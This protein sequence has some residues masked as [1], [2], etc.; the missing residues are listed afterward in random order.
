VPGEQPQELAIDQGSRDIYVAIPLTHFA[1][2]ASELKLGQVDQLSPSGTPT[3]SSPFAAEQNRIFTGVAV[4]PVTHGVYALETSIETPIGPFG[5]SGRMD[6]F[7]SAGTPG[8]EFS[9]GGQINEGPRI[10]ADSTGRVFVP[11]SSAGAVLVYNSSGTL[12]E[13]ITCESCSGGAF[14]QPTSVALDSTDG[15][16]VV[17]VGNDRVVKLTDS[18]GPYAYASL[19]QS[20]KHAAAVGVDPSDNSIFVGDYPGGITYHIVAYDS[21]GM[22]F[23]DFGAGM[24]A[25]VE[26]GPAAAGQIAV[27]ATTHKLYASDPAGNVLHV[28]ELVTINPPTATT[29]IAASVG[30]VEATMK[31][32]VNAN[33]HATTDCH[34]EYADDTSFLANG[35][36]GSSQAPC[37]SRPDGSSPTAV[38]ARLFPLSPDTTYHYRVVA[39]N[40]AGSATGDAVAFSTLSQ[41]PATV[42]TKPASSVVRS[43]ATLNGS[44]N[45][46]SGTVTNCRFEYGPSQTYGETLACP[47]SIGITSSEVTKSVSLS[48]LTPATTYHYRFSVT[49]NAGPVNGEDL[50]VT[51]LAPPPPEEPAPEEA[52]GQEVPFEP[53]QPSV[54]APTPLVASPAKRLVCRKGFRKRRIR[55]KPHCVKKKTHRHKRR[56]RRRHRRSH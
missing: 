7:S 11:S 52:E 46:H 35:F 42:T 41:T 55:G 45:T 43:A 54:T 50:E 19:L 28:F 5:T 27:D 15:L 13:T 51:T 14:Q 22:R 25:S 6:Q 31:A 24:F 49:T 37:S 9:T 23:D 1:T 38:S 44:V 16:Y 56:H 48:G 20:G 17:D 18:G 36:T 10:A 21:S 53:W 30:Q 32:T 47:G 2:D 33:F 8:T 4:N 39:A 34:F 26:Q 12:Q 40:D 3:A 29:D